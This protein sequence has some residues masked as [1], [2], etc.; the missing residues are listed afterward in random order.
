M[1]DDYEAEVT[2][3]DV[4]GSEA[5]VEEIR[6]LTGEITKVALRDSAG[7]MLA[8]YAVSTVQ[9]ALVRV[10]SDILRSRGVSS[11]DFEREIIDCVRDAQ[12]EA[13]V[14]R[15]LRECA[16]RDLISIVGGGSI[17]NPVRKA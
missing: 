17:T 3:L 9:A 14:D 2:D 5:A 13:V 7:P 11:A 1:S 6:E 16:D 10:T 15:L 4:F 8:L 12:S